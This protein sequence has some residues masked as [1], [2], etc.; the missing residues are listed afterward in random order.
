MDCHRIYLP[1]A[2]ENDDLDAF[3]AAVIAVKATI[4]TEDCLDVCDI[5][6]ST[7][8]GGTY[9][10]PMTLLAFAG[11]YGRKHMLEFLVKNGARKCSWEGSGYKDRCHSKKNDTINE[12]A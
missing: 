3:K 12:K 4:P 11:Y 9:Y 8:S 5:V 10:Y 1:Q 2:I 6:S 7:T